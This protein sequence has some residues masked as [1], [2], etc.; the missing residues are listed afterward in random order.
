MCEIIALAVNIIIIIAGAANKRG[1]YFYCIALCDYIYSTLKLHALPHV[2][3]P[4]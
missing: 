3:T 4:S 2:D 1:C